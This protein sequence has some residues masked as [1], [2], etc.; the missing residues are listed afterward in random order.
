MKESENLNLTSLYRKP[1]LWFYRLNVDKNV[2]SRREIILSKNLSPL[3]SKRFLQTRSC[4]RRALGELLKLD[5][6]EVPLL[7]DPNKPPIILN[8]FGHISISHTDN[9]LIIIWD[10]EKI[11][12][13]MERKDRSFDYNMLAKK[14]LKENYELGRF[15][16]LDIL[17]LWCG[18]ESVI[19]WDRGSISKDIN[20]W[21][22]NNIDKTIIHKE[23]KLKLNLNQIYFY[24]WTISFVSEKNLCDFNPVICCF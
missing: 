14:L 5:P 15:E 13:D 11:G 7:A 6:I 22:F 3:N 1:C 23:K 9:A 4:M 12:I 2:N 24:E 20:S 19:K 17:N 10:D 18:F 21:V 16:R 8:G